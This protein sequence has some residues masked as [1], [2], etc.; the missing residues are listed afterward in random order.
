MRVSEQFASSELVGKVVTVDNEASTKSRTLHT[1][2][3]G[4]N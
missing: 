1:L 3:V 2:T 4:G